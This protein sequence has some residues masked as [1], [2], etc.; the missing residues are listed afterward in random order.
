M[1]AS[2]FPEGPVKNLVLLS[3]P[4]E[5]APRNPGPLGLWTHA[6]RN[7]GTFFDP[8]VVPLFFR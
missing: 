1:Y 8:A 6:S 3:A 7:G 5:F 2:L 4:T